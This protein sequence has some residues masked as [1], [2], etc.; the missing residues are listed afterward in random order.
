MSL[1]LAD[2]ERKTQESVMAFWGNRDKAAQKQRESGKVDAG[3]RGAVT[4]GNNMDGFIALVIDLVKAN[5]LAHAQTTSG[6]LSSPCRV[7][8][9]PPN[10]GTC[11]FS[12]RVGSSLRSN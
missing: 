11:W 3:T 7:T 12:T 10:S 4:A 5:G 9:G 6:G 8:S 1:D 2:F